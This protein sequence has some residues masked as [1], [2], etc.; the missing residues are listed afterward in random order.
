MPGLL[1]S[2]R[3]IKRGINALR[4]RALWQQVQMHCEHAYFGND[5]A[6]WTICPNSL[7]PESVVYSFGVGDDISFDLELI[8]RFGLRVY[9]FDPTPKSIEW[10]NKQVLPVEFKF[11]P[12]GVADYDG[13]CKFSPPVNNEHISYTALNRQTP[14]PAIEVPVRCLKTIMRDLGHDK[15][16]L[17]KMDI[18]GAEYS[19]LAD[20]LTSHIRVD[21]LLVEFHHRFPEVGVDKTK[22][23]IKAL[24][25]AGY[26]IFSI[27]PSGE[28]FGFLPPDNSSK[29]E[30]GR[31]ER[32]VKSSMFDS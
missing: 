31:W 29:S 11:S 2:A 20:L 14:W 28:E 18:E 30:S 23:A 32:S 12:C 17:I 19:V 16:N 26:R 24:N 4:G 1:H 9:A 25:A 3:F 5:R 6:G 15:I 10:V 13:I 22:S 27:S 7:S 8:K 21:Q